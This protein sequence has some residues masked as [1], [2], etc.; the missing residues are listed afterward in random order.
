MLPVKS[1]K[2]LYF[3]LKTNKIELNEILENLDHYY[4][5]YPKPKRNKDGTL[6]IKNGKVE[7]RKICPSNGRLK[8]IQSKIKIEI[9]KKIDF[10]EF[11][12]GGVK[13]KDNISNAR[14]HKGNKYFFV[15]DL[16]NFF[17]SVTYEIVYQTLIKYGFSADVSST[18]T[19]LTTYGGNV[20]QGIPTSTHIT[21]L[22]ALPLDYA[23]LKICNENKIR[24]TRFVDDL[25]FSSKS[26]FQHLLSEII[27]T[28]TSQGMRINYRKTRF[29]IGPIEITGIEVRN[30]ILKASKEVHEKYELANNDKKKQSLKSYIERIKKM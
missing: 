17:P 24:Y 10:P 9:L 21:N 1:R 29:K 19:K 22:T 14:V 18:L 6:R 13:G 3:L 28:I 16:N 4:A 27:D 7:T 5:P 8:E 26:D 23:L 11:I 2:Y 15:T 20:P 25:T 12:H 30:N